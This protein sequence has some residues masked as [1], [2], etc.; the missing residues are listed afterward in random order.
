MSLAIKYSRPLLMLGLLALIG[1]LARQAL[2]WG[3]VGAALRGARWA[4]LIPS[5]LLNLVTLGLIILRW[6]HLLGFRTGFQ[7]CLWANQVG[8]YMN[9]LLPFRLGDL[10]RSYLLRRHVPDLSPIA[11][12][13]SIGAELTFDMLILMLLL[14]AL[15]LLL[16]LP[17]LLTQAGALLAVLTLLAV[18]GVLILGRG[19]GPGLR[20]LAGLLHRFLPARLAAPAE[21][22]LGRVQEGLSS[23]QDNRILARV[24]ALTVGG[25]ILQIISNQLLVLMFLPDPPLY[26]GLLVLVGAGLGMALPLLPASAG[27]YE[28]AVT[29]AL[30][31]SGV[32]PEAAAV[33]AVVLRAQQLG[34]TVILGSLG[35]MREGLSLGQVQAATRQAHNN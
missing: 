4:Y 15:V 25:Y 5:T 24:L 16:P 23:I 17:P 2:D 12:L 6:Q 8:A 11:I 30:A 22:L 19:E 28:L 31:S 34:M 9:T 26:A 27:T 21:H 1:L 18:L 32:A 13:S 14:A 10:T 29:L 7:N 33:V 35:L 3:E 20:W